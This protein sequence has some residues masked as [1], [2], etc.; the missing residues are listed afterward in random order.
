MS[1]S[2]AKLGSVKVFT[3]H[4]RGASIEEI[5][6]RAVDRII[7]IGDTAHPVIAAQ[8]HAY[9]EHIRKVLEFYLAEA[10]KADRTTL[11]NWLRAQGYAE[12]VP[13]VLEDQKWL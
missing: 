13:L 9:K 3:T 8:A 2:E 7:S 10:V 1:L 5:A 4:R 11:A 12:L 6:D